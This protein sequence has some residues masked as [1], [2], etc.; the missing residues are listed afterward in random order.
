MVEKEAKIFMM[1]EKL[2]KEAEKKDGS[3][4]NILGIKRVK[5]GDLGGVTRELDQ[6]ICLSR[7]RD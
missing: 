3:L 1:E 2:N 7:K 6:V 4:Y 5:K